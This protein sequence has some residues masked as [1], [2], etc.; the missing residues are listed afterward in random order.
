MCLKVNAVCFYNSTPFPLCLDTTKSTRYNENDNENN[1]DDADYGKDG[2]N[3]NDDLYIWEL[4]VCVSVTFFLI[5]FSSHLPPP[6]LGKLFWQVNF[7]S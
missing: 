2:N 4:S 3:D 5:F 7:F 6:L 1:D